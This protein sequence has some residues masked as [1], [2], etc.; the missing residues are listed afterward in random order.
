MVKVVVIRV[1][2]VV[3]SMVIGSIVG[4]LCVVASMGN[5]G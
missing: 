4:V 2:G 5:G 3:G 1:C